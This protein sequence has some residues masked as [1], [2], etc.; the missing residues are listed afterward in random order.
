[1]GKLA[2]ID[3]CIF[4]AYLAFVFALGLWFARRQRD[5]EEYFVGGRKMNWFAVGVSLFATAFSSISFVALPKEGVFGDYHLLV[6]YLCIPLII[7]PLLW[8]VFVPVYHRLGLTS[9]YEYLEI[10]FNRPMRRL[11]TLL[12]ALYVVGWMGSMVFATGL[13]VKA[14]LNLSSDQFTWTLIAIGLFA[15]VYTAIGGIRAVIWT[16]VLQ[17]AT[18][19]GGMVAVLLLT[20][21]QI[22]GGWS[23]VVQI[24]IEHDK[25]QMFDMDWDPRRSG[26]FF[27]ALMLGLFAYLPG[28]AVAQTT[29]QRYLCTDRLSSARRA[30]LINAAVATLVAVLFF[31]VGTTLFAYYQQAGS[32][33]LPKLETKDQIM[34]HF[35]LT[36]LSYTGLSGL[37]L[38]G[39]FAAVMSTIDS[40][41]NALTAVVVYDWLGG[42]RTQVWLSRL[43]CGVFGLGVI[44]ASLLASCVGK[45]VIDIIGMIAGAFL[46]LLFGVFLIGLLVR[47]GNTQGALVGLVAG[48]ISLAVVWTKTDIH[49]WWY[50]AFTCL[51]VFVCG[52][53]ASYL[54]PP[55]REEQLTGLVFSKS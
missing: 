50:G 12:F 11:G 27:S 5:T 49:A 17:A 37:L 36:E 39:L 30:L 13:I 33:G 14:A 29:V 52:S 26:T 18:L 47:R 55:P 15:T 54:F 1:M 41:I 40:G 32:A 16:D 10:R 8:W 35:V 43:L 20:M 22:D 31:F 34:P 48:S 9:V 51:P 7:T 2:V 4:A 42:R 38:A 44:G 46:G 23:A 6:T 21:R 24:G 53:L 25:F 19:G 28:Y 3:W 45:T